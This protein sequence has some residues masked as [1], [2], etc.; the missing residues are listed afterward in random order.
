[1]DG[2]IDGL[3][4]RQI[5]WWMDELM[6]RWKNDLANNIQSHKGHYTHDNMNRKYEETSLS[7]IIFIDTHSISVH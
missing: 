7:I 5:N 3:V 4:D 1:M 2:Y 6:N